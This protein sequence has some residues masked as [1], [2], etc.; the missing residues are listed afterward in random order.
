MIDLISRQDAIDTHCAICPDKSKCSDGDF[1]CPDRELF[2]MIKALHPDIKIGKWDFIGDN[3][4]RCTNCG[5]VYLSDT[6]ERLRQKLDDPIFPR[7]C[8]D[9]GEKK[10]VEEPDD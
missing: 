4:F 2:R 9:C 3:L 5:A 8:P 1:V 7:F 6:L 10:Q